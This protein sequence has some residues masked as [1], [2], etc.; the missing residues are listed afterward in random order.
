MKILI[1]AL[2]LVPGIGGV[3]AATTTKFVNAWDYGWTSRVVGDQCQLS[4]DLPGYGEARFAANRASSLHF[5]LQAARDLQS[6]PLVVWRETPAWS[7]RDGAALTL[8]ELHHIPGGGSAIEGNLAEQMFV[9]LREGYDLTLR[10]PTRAG[11]AQGL[12]LR[13]HAMDFFPA[14]QNFLDCAHTSVLVDWLSISRTRV[15]FEVDEHE[16]INNPQL[17]ALLAYVKHNPAV[18]TIYVDGH[19]DNS[20]NERSNYQLA[21]RR[22]EAVARYL[23]EGGIGDRKFVIRYHGERYPVASNDTPAGRADNRRATIRLERQAPDT[24]ATK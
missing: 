15:N 19:T 23:T 22:A 9:A 13:M 21:K 8:G 2:L 7:Q 24:V 10:G 4:I 14:M 16:V 5:E 18:S 12:L 6:A 3:S 20:G 11:G 17:E 1:A